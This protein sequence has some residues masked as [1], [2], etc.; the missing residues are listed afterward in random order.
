MVSKA[1]SFLSCCSVQ[2]C[3]ETGRAYVQW[4]GQMFLLGCH[5]L[6][7]R[8]IMAGEDPLEQKNLSSLSCH[9][10]ILFGLSAQC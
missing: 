7:E 8:G 6:S 4:A 5:L 2:C 10:K 3:N 1:R 9:R